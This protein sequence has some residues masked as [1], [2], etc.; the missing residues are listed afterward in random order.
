MNIHEKI[1]SR[2][3]YDGKLHPEALKF[4][5]TKNGV[6][7][8]TP[9]RIRILTPYRYKNLITD[10]PRRIGEFLQPTSHERNNSNIL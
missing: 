3:W 1:N 6:E 10:K 2:S 8:Y 9:E 7:H 5:G 4:C